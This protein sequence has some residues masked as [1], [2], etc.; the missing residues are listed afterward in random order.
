[1]AMIIVAAGVVPKVGATSPL[2]V[3][4][5]IMAAFPGLRDFSALNTPLSHTMVGIG[6][7]LALLLLG[8]KTVNLVIAALSATVG[9]SASCQSSGRSVS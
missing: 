5:G 4:S 6:T 7:H 3:T 2:G 8:R 1:M 9:T